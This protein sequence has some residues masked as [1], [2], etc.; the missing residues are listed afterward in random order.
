[1]TWITTDNK[2]IASLEDMPEG[3]F[4]FCYLIQNHTKGKSYIGKKQVISITKKKFGKKKLAQMTDKR[5]KKYEMVLKE[6]NWKD[7]TGSNKTLLEDVKNDDNITKIILE[8]GFSKWHLTYLEVKYQFK[9]DVLES[10]HWYNDNILS[11]FFRSIFDFKTD[12]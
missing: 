7:Y 3:V 11:K 4:G 6:S 10:D 1:M 5:S 8:F 9:N 12:K 2:I